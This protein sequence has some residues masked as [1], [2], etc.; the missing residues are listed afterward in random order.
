LTLSFG[1][2][3][4]SS[5][6]NTTCAPGTTSALL[7]PVPDRAGAAADEHLVGRARSRQPSFR[8]TSIQ[9]DVLTGNSNR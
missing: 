4:Q 6:R 1:L 7:L 9:A 5:F 3:H 2:R 8:C